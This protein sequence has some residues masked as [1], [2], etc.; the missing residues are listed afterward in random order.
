MWVDNMHIKRK[1]TKRIV[2]ARYPE[3]LI[4]ELDMIA[5]ENRQDRTATMQDILKKG[6]EDHKKKRVSSYLSYAIVW[7]CAIYYTQIFIPF[8]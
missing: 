4:Q 6:V 2:A 7:L 1:K 5:A 3:K 8:L